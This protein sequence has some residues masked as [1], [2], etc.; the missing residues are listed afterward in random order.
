M[1]PINDETGA[2]VES[3]RLGQRSGIGAEEQALTTAVFI[4]LGIG[5]LVL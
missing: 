4:G 1:R 3:P 5:R 2:G